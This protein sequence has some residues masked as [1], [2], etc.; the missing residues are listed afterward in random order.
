MQ[1]PRGGSTVYRN[2]VS[3]PSVVTYS[4]EG[5]GGTY[6]GNQSQISGVHTFAQSGSLNGNVQTVRLD[7]GDH[8]EG[9]LRDGLF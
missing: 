7:N 8:Y 5:E 2:Q 1:S 6:R 9:G 3:S 4:Y